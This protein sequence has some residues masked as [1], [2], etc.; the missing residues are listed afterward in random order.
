MLITI[1]MPQKKVA[2]LG[3]EIEKE[4]YLE[5][6]ENEGVGE[7]GLIISMIIEPGEKHGN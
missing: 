3:L 6:Y 2:R 7:K 4:V 5:E 1:Q